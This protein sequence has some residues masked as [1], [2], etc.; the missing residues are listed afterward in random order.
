M[1]PLTRIPVSIEVREKL[2]Q[3]GDEKDTYDERILKLIKFYE[4]NKDVKRDTGETG[5]LK[6]DEKL[7][8]ILPLIDKYVKEAINKYLPT[9]EVER[10]IEVGDVFKIPRRINLSPQT[11]QYYQWYVTK[12]GGDMSID[13]FINDVIEEHFTECLNVEIGIITRPGKSRRLRGE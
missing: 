4:E 12:S 8:G 9:R 7:E 10:E 3:I 6:L 5:K 13:E 11:I 2:K 1:S